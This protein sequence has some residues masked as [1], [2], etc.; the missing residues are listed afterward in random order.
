M[1]TPSKDS[2][3]QMIMQSTK[4]ALNQCLKK[5]AIAMAFAT[6]FC[7]FTF[8]Q[9]GSKGDALARGKYIVED[10]AVCGQCH[11]PRDTM[12]RLDRSRWLQGAPLWINPTHP[13]SDWPMQ[14]PR[15]AG[16][17]PAGDD[18]MVKLL[19]TGIWTDGTYLHEPMPQFRMTPED[20]EAVVAYL[21]SVQTAK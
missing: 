12:N 14:A 4:F 7:V 13:A 18:E 10:V 5:T 21:K 11:T 16:A 15:I 1:P 2:D 8:S 19:T 3:N 9:N 17:L 20:A 6:A